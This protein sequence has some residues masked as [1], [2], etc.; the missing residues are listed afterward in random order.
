MLMRIVR[1][2]WAGTRNAKAQESFRL[3][4]RQGWQADEI[5]PPYKRSRDS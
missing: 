4:W 5:A 3:Y 2:E 1:S